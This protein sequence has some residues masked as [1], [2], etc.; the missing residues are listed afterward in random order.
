MPTI[1]HKH[2]GSVV[3]GWVTDGSAE[4]L[5]STLFVGYYCDEEECPE[6]PDTPCDIHPE[7]YWEGVMID[8]WRN[9]ITENG[10]TA[11]EED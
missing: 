8:R 3:S 6:D 10:Y 5:E 7:G 2:S 4:W 1:E 11:T 9:A